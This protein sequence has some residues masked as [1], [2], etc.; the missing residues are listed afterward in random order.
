M[1]SPPE[2][3]RVLL[4]ACCLI[5]LLATDRHEEILRILPWACATSR[6]IL[7]R[8]ILF[9]AR[10]A[11][12]GALLEQEIIPPER[13]EGLD[14]LTILEVSSHRVSIEL[15]RFAAEEVDDGEASICALAVVHGGAVAT[16]DRRALRV[17]SR[18]APRVPILQTPELLYEWA[19][20]SRAS[21]FEIADALRLVQHR[22]RFLPSRKAPRFEWWE[23]F[24]SRPGGRK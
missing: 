15:R 9:L 11:A 14:H 10:G 3:S 12:P 2:G 1:P 13:L 16:D 20:L 22:A 23:S 19:R 5:N 21:K 6:L 18:I 24:F 17:L 7:S 8:E 4:D